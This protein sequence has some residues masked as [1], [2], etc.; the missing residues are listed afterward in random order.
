[1]NLHRIV[2]FRCPHP[3]C[4]R[5][6]NV[7]SNMRRHFRNHTLPGTC[8]LRRSSRDHSPQ[9][10]RTQRTHVSDR[11]LGLPNAT[12]G[13]MSVSTPRNEDSGADVR[14]G[15]CMHNEEGSESDVGIDS[16]T[17]QSRSCRGDQCD[18]SDSSE[19]KSSSPSPTTPGPISTFKSY[20]SGCTPL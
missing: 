1:L 10:Q 16:W 5:E 11:A 2:A 13:P 20:R 4:G 17:Y 12:D 8:Q 7:N 18:E 9:I 3:T 15:V 14:F 6:F 19:S